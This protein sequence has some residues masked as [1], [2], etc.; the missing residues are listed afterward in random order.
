MKLPLSDRFVLLP[1]AARS[2]AEPDRPST[3]MSVGGDSITGVGKSPSSTKINELL[4]C[5]VVG[6][7]AET[8]RFP[9]TTGEALREDKS[10]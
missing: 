9:M 6:V 5:V 4:T 1:T 8:A 2:A 10:Q 3:A 7:D